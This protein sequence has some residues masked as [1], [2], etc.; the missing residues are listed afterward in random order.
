MRLIRLIREYWSEALTLLVILIFFFIVTF[1]SYPDFLKKLVIDYNHGTDLAKETS[2][3]GRGNFGDMYGALNTF[4]SG[5]AFLGLLVTIGVQIYIHKLSNDKDIEKKENKEKEKKSESYSET[6]Q[7]ISYYHSIISR[8][9]L[10]NKLFIEALIKFDNENPVDVLQPK[11]LV[12]QTSD[13]ILEIA[14]KKINHETYYKHYR[15]WH[16]NNNNNNILNT[17]ETIDMVLDIRQLVKKNV[18]QYFTKYNN[19]L[20]DIKKSLNELSSIIK[21]DANY[22][23][24]KEKF[25]EINFNLIETNIDFL[26]SQLIKFKND[27]IANPIDSNAEIIAIIDSFDFFYT[28]QIHIFS[29]LKETFKDDISSLTRGNSILTEFRDSL[30][31]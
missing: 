20:F 28:N 1:Y 10:S 16:N 7:K 23:L 6:F 31:F 21:R 22:P 29:I 11:V 9:I 13:N 12:L 30:T 19:K 3:F 18:E 8:V 26:H 25:I 2:E 17:F 15:K 27:L 24:H 14:S 5:L 4:F